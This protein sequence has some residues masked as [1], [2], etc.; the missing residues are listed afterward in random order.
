[1]KRKGIIL[2]GGS[3]T[4]LWPSTRVLS[5][6][7]IPVFDKPMI[8]YP[9]TTLMLAGIREILVISTPTDL[10]RFK[11][12]LGD[13]HD[14][15]L[16]LSY[17]EQARPEG[18]AQAFI[19]GADFIGSDTVALVLGDNIFFGQGMPEQLQGASA[20]PSGATIFAYHVKDPERYGVVE[21]GSDGLARSIEEKP[22]HPK[23]SY[24]VVGLYFYDN[25][26]VELA[27]N[28]SPSPRD[29]LEITDLNRLFLE[30]GQL[31][32]QTLGR[33]VAWLDTGTHDALL[34][35]SNFVAVVEE[36]QGLKIG[37]PEEA[38]YRMGFIDDD[39]VRKLAAGLGASPY[40]AYLISM[41]DGHGPPR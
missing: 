38:A 26:V 13:G 6:Q 29:E 20:Q 21:F 39:G 30:R 40:A 35:A 9:L 31:T 33:G 25:S 34:A 1:M 18:L 15:G 4:R 7:L 32:V 17:A 8:Y 12:L 2:A 36:R 41:L 24:A 23:S 3:G 11:D 19:I 27:R 37:S 16:E 14:L 28:L 5:K 22:A 10:P